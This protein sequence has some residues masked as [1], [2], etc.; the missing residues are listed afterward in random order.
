MNINVRSNIA[1]IAKKLDATQRQQL[2]F[3]TA[4]L[5]YPN[6]AGY[7]IV[8]GDRVTGRDETGELQY[9]GWFSGYIDHILNTKEINHEF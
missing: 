8:Q 2:P 1:E 5:R 9:E 3:A 6:G 4:R 7:L